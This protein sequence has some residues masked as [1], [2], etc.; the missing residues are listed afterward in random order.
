MDKVIVMMIMLIT[1]VM[2]IAS[3][4][5]T[6]VGTE[7]KCYQPKKAAPIEWDKRDWGRKF[8]NLEQEDEK[9]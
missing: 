2:L 5:P 6:S 3:N 7:M 8:A 4:K 1:A 9:P